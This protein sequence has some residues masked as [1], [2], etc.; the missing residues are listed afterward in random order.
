LNKNIKEMIEYPKEGIL[1]KKI[2]KNN[3]VDVT[4]FCMTNGSELSEHTSTKGGL[5]FVIEG[6]GVFNLQGKKIKMLPGVFISMDKNSIHS[7]NVSENTSF[8]LTLF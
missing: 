2:V 7:L 5:I 1:T 6:N 8:M 3:E 4:L